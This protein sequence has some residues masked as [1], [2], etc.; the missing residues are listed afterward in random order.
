MSARRALPILAIVGMLFAIPGI[1][2][3]AGTP[4]VTTSAASSITSTSATLN[5]TVNPAKQSTTYS[6][7]YGATTGYGAST[8]AQAVGG[9]GTKSVSATISGLLPSTTYH[10]RLIA[11]NASGPSTGQD[12]T[13]TTATAGAVAPSKDAVSITA[14]PRT[15][16]YGRSGT[17][18]GAVKGPRSGGVELI[19]A[20]QPYPFT[21]PFRNVRTTTAAANGSYGFVIAPRTR[22][23]YEVV[24][25]TPQPALSAVVSVGVRYAVWFSVSTTVVRRGSFV[26]F[27]GGT[28]PA[29]NGR[30]ILIQRRTNTGVF[31]TVART[32]L[33]RTTSRTRSSY[34]IRIRIRAGGVYRVRMPAHTPYASANSRLR[35]ITVR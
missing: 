10:Y 1:A 26:R 14:A 2:E 9:N 7:Q 11:A 3:A 28:H 25:R 24:A 8:A 35:T 30:D 16:T 6:F 17:I 34:S 33:H 19:L 32:L 12:V 5:G 18:T 4:N 20:A 13:F 21:A 29:A 22:T 23:R 31:R 27:Y 15:V